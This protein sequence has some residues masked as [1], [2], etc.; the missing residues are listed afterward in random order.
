MSR[1]LSHPSVEHFEAMT[2][3]VSDAIIAVD[4]PGACCHGIP[5]QKIFQSKE[6]EAPGQPVTI[7]IPRQSRK[8]NDAGIKRVNGECPNDRD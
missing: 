7:I 5:R 6:D 8:A 4:S 1:P 3:A 2:A